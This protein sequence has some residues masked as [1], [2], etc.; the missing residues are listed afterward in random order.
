MALAPEL[1]RETPHQPA[2]PFGQVV[3]PN[4]GG[5]DGVFEADLGA[6]M[7][8][9]RAKGE[10]ITVKGR[11]L[12][13]VGSPVGDTLVEIWQADAAGIYASPEDPRRGADPHFTGFGRRGVDLKTAA[14]A[15]ATIKPGRVPFRDGRL[16]A[17]HIGVWLFAAGLTVGLQTRIY[18]ADEAAANA[19]DPVLARVPLLR[20]ATL[21]APR[22][23]DT[24]TFDIRLRGEGETVFF[25]I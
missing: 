7:V 24:Y 21:I 15:F 2:G 3:I 25:D 12:D 20:R 19:K 23:G 8:G 9:E 4:Y 10:R 6:T 17:P 18:F 5:I 11:V 14:F 1:L 22:K 13:E 16:M